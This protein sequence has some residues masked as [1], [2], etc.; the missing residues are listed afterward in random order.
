MM[1]TGGSMLWAS[2]LIIFFHWKQLIVVFKEAACCDY[3]AEGSHVL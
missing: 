2:D 1:F 3:C